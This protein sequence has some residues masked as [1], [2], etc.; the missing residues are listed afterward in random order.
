MILMQ[1]LTI[2]PLL[3][4]NFLSSNNSNIQISNPKIR[5]SNPNIRNGNLINALK[6]MSIVAYYAS[7]YLSC[8]STIRFRYATNRISPYIDKKMMV[9]VFCD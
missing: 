1:R 4:S 8:P 7:V 3:S 9:I 5:I 6:N 2:Y